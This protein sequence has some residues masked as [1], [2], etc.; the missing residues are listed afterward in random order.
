MPR[1]TY[2]TDLKKFDPVPHLEHACEILG[3]MWL[4]KPGHRTPGGS[5]VA[6]KF[7]S[8]DNLLAS[9][10]DSIRQD[11]DIRKRW[12]LMADVGTMCHQMIE[13]WLN[14]LANDF[15]EGL[16]HMVKSHTG[17]GVTF[18]EWQ[19]HCITSRR[20]L[21]GFVEWYER[22]AFRR[23]RSEFSMVSDS[24]RTGGT[25]DHVFEEL[26]VGN[27][28]VD[29]KTKDFY[30]PDDHPRFPGKRKRV[31]PSAT[32]AMQ[33]GLYAH[34]CEHGRP[35]KNHGHEDPDSL[36]WFVG[37]PIQRAYVWFVSRETAEH[38]ILVLDETALRVGYALAVVFRAAM[39][40]QDYLCGMFPPD[41]HTHTDLT[42]EQEQEILDYE[43]DQVEQ[44]FDWADVH[45][46]GKEL[47]D[48]NE[49]TDL[50]W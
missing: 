20:A 17:M 37:Q 35:N 10:T 41:H 33:L 1:V 40:A 50:Q 47:S 29:V 9:A 18:E 28:L 31:Y 3:E 48:G 49:E 23:H 26:R 6:S 36:R 4:A 24:L 38:K 5:T 34:F 19:E 12:S 11:V 45:V 21:N 8:K 39:A 15:D 13:N 42:E 46:F 30:Y 16:F 22:H 14:G 43:E 32:Y 44:F 7:E 2:T 27:I 25:L